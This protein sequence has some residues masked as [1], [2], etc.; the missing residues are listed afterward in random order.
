MKMQRKL[1]RQMRREQRQFKR[2]EHER[3]RREMAEA[4]GWQDAIGQLIEAAQAQSQEDIA[5][6]AARAAVIDVDADAVDGAP[7]P[8]RNPQPCRSLEELVKELDELERLKK[9]AKKGKKAKTE[10]QGAADAAGAASSAALEGAEGEHPEGAE[11]EATAQGGAEGN[12]QPQPVPND[13]LNPLNA[14]YDMKAYALLR[15]LRLDEEHQISQI[16]LDEPDWDH[17]GY[18][19]RSPSPCRLRTKGAMWPTRKGAWRSR[20]GGVFLPPEANVERQGSPSLSPARW[21]YPEEFNRPLQKARR[22]PSYTRM[23]REEI[24][25]SSSSDSS[26]EQSVAVCNNMQQACNLGCRFVR[27]NERGLLSESLSQWKELMEKDKARAGIELM[28][29]RWARGDTAG[30]LA[31]IFVVWKRAVDERKKSARR[32]RAHQAVNMLLCTW[33]RPGPQGVAACAIS[34]WSRYAAK[35]RGRTRARLAMES[36]PRD[37][38]CFTLW[39]GFASCKCS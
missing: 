11:G 21:M 6:K 30:L 29:Q 14:A 33:R 4:D 36:S 5:A 3:L 35:N 34:A 9:E 32:D 28:I 20:A 23:E 18:L 22:S 26:W 31:E 13:P 12:A 10:A 16:A 17:L 24:S 19:R 39:D 27:G 25:S 7:S 15:K 1:A 38:S 2:E 8:V 37:G